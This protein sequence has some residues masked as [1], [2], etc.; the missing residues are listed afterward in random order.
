M[1]SRNPWDSEWEG[2]DDAPEGGPLPSTTL[3]KKS[4]KRRGKSKKPIKKRK[5]KRKEKKL[6]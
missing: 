3:R 1:E 2:V 5:T 6:N 4:R